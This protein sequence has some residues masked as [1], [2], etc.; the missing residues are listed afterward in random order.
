[1]S[2]FKTRYTFHSDVGHA[3]LAVKRVELRRL[4]LLDEISRYSY[5][6]GETVYLEED[7]DAD[8]FIKKKEALGEPV[9][10]REKHKDTDHYIRKF[11]SYSN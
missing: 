6:N 11:P 7:C 3:W 5:Q 1:M 9:T 4:E 8:I 2:N 10:F